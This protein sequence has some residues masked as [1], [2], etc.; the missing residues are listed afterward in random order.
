MSV[1]NG[2]QYKHPNTL[3]YSSPFMV[4]RPVSWMNF[5]TS[6]NIC[7][8]V[9]SL[10]ISLQNNKVGSSIDKSLLISRIPLKFIITLFK[11][12]GC[13]RN[14]NLFLSNFLISFSIL[15]ESKHELKKPTIRVIRYLYKMLFSHMHPTL[16][17]KGCKVS[18]FR[19]AKVRLTRIILRPLSALSF[20][21]ATSGSVI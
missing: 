10:S 7:V 4:K 18:C 21:V 13:T 20:N 12:K 1:M 5:S 16:L 8:F 3:S 9:S 2:K 15:F 14:A 17:I 19:R 11:P 6:K